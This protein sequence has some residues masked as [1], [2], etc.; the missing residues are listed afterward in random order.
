MNV[1]TGC[2][3]MD[4]SEKINAI[5]KKKKMSKKNFAE[6]L[7]NLEPKLKRTGETP[8]VSTI[9]KYLS[10]DLTIPVEIIPF[11]A[12]V[13]HVPEQE[14]FNLSLE[15]KRKCIQYVFENSSEK[16]VQYLCNYTNT[17][18]AHK[19]AFLDIDITDAAKIK[20]I[21]ELLPYAP[22]ILIEQTIKKLETIKKQLS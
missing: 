18:Q 10:G 13:L 16:E 21:L 4:V 1:I 17:F 9:Y 22:G 14:F 3:F 2:D 7:I 19:T 11:M 8:K 12:E 6:Q 5:L 20:K 15:T